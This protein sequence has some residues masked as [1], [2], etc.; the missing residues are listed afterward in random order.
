MRS[1]LDLVLALSV[2]IFAGAAAAMDATAVSFDEN[3]SLTE[4]D[5]TAYSLSGNGRF[6]TFR[7]SQPLMAADTTGF[8]VY[9]RDLETDQLELISVRPDGTVSAFGADAQS[10]STRLISHDGR[11]VLFSSD[12]DDLVPE[13]S[14]SGT[15][16]LYLRDR[17]TQTTTL[18]DADN[19]GV[20]ADAAI[21][22]KYTL[23]PSGLAVMFGSTATNLD[24][25]WP[26]PGFAVYLHRQDAPI[27]SSVRTR[28]ACFGTLG[29][30]IACSNYE[31][32]CGGGAFA[33]LSPSNDVAPVT[34]TRGVYHGLPIAGFNE[35][36]SEDLAG[37]SN[38]IPGE[39]S[40][41]CAGN[42]I[43]FATT[44]GL[45]ADDDAGDWDL[46]VVDLHGPKVRI[47]HQGA[48]VFPATP[49]AAR[50][51]SSGSVVAFETTVAIDPGDSN[52]DFDTYYLEID[53]DYVPLQAAPML[54]SEVDGTV[55][56]RS[57]TAVS[58]ADNGGIGFNSRA[59]N[60]PWPASAFNVNRAYVN[61][62]ALEILRS[63][64]FE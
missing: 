58:P 25:A 50:L 47:R 56:N 32:A 5:I 8:Q 53:R 16:H 6:A 26:N 12:A 63:N 54:A 15:P 38:R 27:G 28:R 49:S 59:N 9:V 19:N 13:V 39:P 20:P 21:N 10:L 51:S 29:Q 44:A 62:V 45:F 33:F 3:G 14:T 4:T 18:V 23:D 42:R 17:E 48:S 55:G 43:A 31:L 57:A 22:G 64:G 2:A 11:Y 60:A 41:N 35:L 7:S 52:N 61:R 1:M 37:V 24:A 34:D 36:V 46:Y 30:P 40:I